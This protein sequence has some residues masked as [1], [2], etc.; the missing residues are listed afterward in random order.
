MRCHSR[1][2]GKVDGQTAKGWFLTGMPME[3]MEGWLL[4]GLREWG[5]YWLGLVWGRGRG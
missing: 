1:H 2:R 5:E 4:S 3:S